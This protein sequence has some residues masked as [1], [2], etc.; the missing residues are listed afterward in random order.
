M[1]KKIDFLPAIKKQGSPFFMDT[2][3]KGSMNQGSAYLDG[4]QL[5]KLDSPTRSWSKSPKMGDK[6]WIESANKNGTFFSIEVGQEL[7]KYDEDL[8]KYMKTTLRGI[9]KPDSLLS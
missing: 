8:R 2:N 6:T 5:I 3:K 4:R 1:T 9:N 7:D